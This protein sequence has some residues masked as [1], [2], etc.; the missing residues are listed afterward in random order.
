[1]V[2]ETNLWGRKKGHF[3][4]RFADFCIL[5]LPHTHRENQIQHFNLRAEMNRAALAAP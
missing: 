4:L 5:W 3:V 1:M 2:L